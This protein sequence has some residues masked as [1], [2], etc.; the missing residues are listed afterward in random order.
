VR[1]G[2][3]VASLLLAAP[4]G[5][6]AATDAFLPAG[7]PLEAELRILDLTD[8]AGGGRILLP[9]LHTRPLQ[10]RELM[11]SAAPPESADVGRAIS[12]ARLERALGRHARPGFDPHPAWSST[13]FLWH[14]ATA[15]QSAELSAGLE[16]RGE[17]DRFDSRFTSGT[18]AQAR[19]AA[20][21]DHWLVYSHLLIGQ[22]DGANTFADPIVAG[23]EII[24]HTED[25][26]VA[27]T[28]Q[29]GRWGAWLGRS[30]WHWGPGEEASLA[31][32]K[33]SPAFTGLAAR[34]R[35]EPLRAD[36]I[37]LSGTLDQATGEQLAAHRLEWQPAGRLRVGLTETARY[38]AAS[39][40]PL[41]LVGVIPYILVQRLETQEN[42]DSAEAL[43]NNVMMSVDLAWRP[44]TG[45][46]LY[47]ELLI[48]DLHAKSTANPDKIAFQLGWEGVG[49]VGRTR[50]SWGGEYTRLSRYV[51]TSYFGRAYEVQGRPTG[52]PTGPDA[53]RLSLRGAWDFNAD[54]Q[55]AARVAQTDQGEGSLDRPYVPGSPHG[56]P[57]AFEG[58]V[59]RTRT[60]E[61]G[62]RWWPASGVDLSAWAGYLSVEDAGHVAGASRD[63][64]TAALEV[65]LTR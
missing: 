12:L 58:V 46:R 37:V 11:G 17:T 44:V 2:L 5:A 43:R 3:W 60:G 9:H 53:G 41:Y 6:R 32:S 10:W 23:S 26:Y 38:H 14:S 54:W 52:Y 16:G 64:P 18:G 36:A 4:S 55:L 31:L 33:T 40:Q 19:F 20:A 8:P 1:H 62:L 48:D 13:P 29:D 57:F 59:E 34:G 65:R 24:V 27:Y 7:D 56:D 30:R 22:V 50:V 61:L 49:V 39:W 45:T 51:Y 15:G 28:G 63:T 42:P 47:A 35:I 21:F 25:T